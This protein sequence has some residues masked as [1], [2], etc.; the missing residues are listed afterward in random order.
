MRR[1][2]G[3]FQAHSNVRKLLTD[4]TLRL[5]VNIYDTEKKQYTIPDNVVGLPAPPTESFTRTS[6][7]VFNYEPSPFAFWITRRSR[8]LATPLFDTRISSLPSTP[9]VPFISNDSSTA[10]DR[11]SLVFEDR[12]LQVWHVSLH[13]RNASDDTTAFLSFA[14]RYQ[15][16]WLG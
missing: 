14:S 2:H 6:D 4:G 3:T 5:H 9:T 7:L 8:P 11:F 16:I 12:Y 13:I 10:F 15:Y 1:N